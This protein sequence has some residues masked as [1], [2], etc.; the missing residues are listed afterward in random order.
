MNA[1]IIISTL[2][3]LKYFTQRAIPRN[4]VI[5]CT[6][7]SIEAELQS[8]SPEVEGLTKQEIGYTYIEEIRGSYFNAFPPAH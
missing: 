5:Q 3:R 7:R 2:H 1:G 6:G 8:P 4:V